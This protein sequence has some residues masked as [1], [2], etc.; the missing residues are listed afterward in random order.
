MSIL[1]NPS[2]YVGRTVQIKRWGRVVEASLYKVVGQMF[3]ASY[4]K[5]DGKPM[6]GM[7][8]FVEVEN[9]LEKEDD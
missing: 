7:V 8:S 9:L 1:E 2:R 4:L 6:R 3:M 5:P